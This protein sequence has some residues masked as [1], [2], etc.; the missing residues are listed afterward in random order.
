MHILWQSIKIL[1]STM[2]NNPLLFKM[3][4]DLT[5]RCIS[6]IVSQVWYPMLSQAFLGWRSAHISI[7]DRSW[8]RIVCTV[9][10]TVA[11]NFPA[12]NE[13]VEQSTTETR[14]VGLSNRD[15]PQAPLSPSNWSALYRRSRLVSHELNTPQGVLIGAGQ[16]LQHGEVRDTNLAWVRPVGLAIITPS[17]PNVFFLPVEISVYAIFTGS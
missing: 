7:E 16:P 6:H 5:A 13:T 1:Q 8:V 3:V 11:T 14:T 9:Y 15:W 10:A 17:T 2:E 4:T 12:L